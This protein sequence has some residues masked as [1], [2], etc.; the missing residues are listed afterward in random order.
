MRKALQAWWTLQPKAK[1]APAG[2]R[3]KENG[4]GLWMLFWYVVSDTS[5]EPFMGLSY[6]VDVLQDQLAGV[7]VHASDCDFALIAHVDGLA[8]VDVNFHELVKCL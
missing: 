6:L 3:S 5:C 8:G 1:G 7:V 4:V 2:R